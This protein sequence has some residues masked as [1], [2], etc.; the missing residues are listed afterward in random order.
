MSVLY[1][2]ELCAGMYSLAHRYG[3]MFLCFAEISVCQQVCVPVTFCCS[4]LVV[5]FYT[6]N[7]GS[8][9]S[10]REWHTEMI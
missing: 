5:T 7:D 3:N 9:V 2:S 10:A 8:D 6:L 4:G 1:S